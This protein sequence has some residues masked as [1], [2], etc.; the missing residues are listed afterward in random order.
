MA[1]LPNQ[2]HLRCTHLWVLVVWSWILN[3]LS[4]FYISYVFIS[5]LFLKFWE[6]YSCF[7]VISIAS[8]F[9]YFA[10]SFLI[11]IPCFH[12]FKKVLGVIDINKIC[13]INNFWHTIT[14]SLILLKILLLDF[15]RKA[16]ICFIV[17]NWITSIVI[18]IIHGT[19]HL[20]YTYFRR[21]NTMC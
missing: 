15:I 11:F 17:W 8:L 12:S 9:I 18:Y 19:N 6:L 3:G 16:N 21:S 10:R 5:L 2:Y 20:L 4:L 14:C 13:I 1:T 7:R